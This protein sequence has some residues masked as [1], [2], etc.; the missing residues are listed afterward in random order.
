MLFRNCTIAVQRSSGGPIANLAIEIAAK[1]EEGLA[2][3]CVPDLSSA[4]IGAIR[5]FQP[6]R[7]DHPDRA[8]RPE[9]E[10]P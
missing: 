1:H 8:D 6:G 2:R 3:V 5:Q 9:P 7:T 10:G 4:S